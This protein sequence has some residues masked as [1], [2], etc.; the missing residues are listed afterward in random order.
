MNNIQDFEEWIKTIAVYLLNRTGSYQVHSAS[1]RFSEKI[2]NIYNYDK[3]ILKKQRTGGRFHYPF[4]N[5]SEYICV[6]GGNGK[7]ES[8]FVKNIIE[9][10]FPA[11]HIS[12]I[13]FESWR[14]CHYDD[15][16]LKYNSDEIPYEARYKHYGNSVEEKTSN[17]IDTIIKQ[18]IPTFWRDDIKLHSMYSQKVLKYAIDRLLLSSKLKYY[19]VFWNIFLLAIDDEI[20]DKQISDV[21][22]L[23]QLVGF[24]EA[25]MRDWCRAVEYVMEGNM[26]SKDCDFQCETDEGKTFF[27]HQDQS[28]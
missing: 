8:N 4:P 6:A 18:N 15:K 17:F 7:S 14:G 28:V 23:A 25:M 11:W 21:M 9:N 16:S 22:S 1:T 13:F 27:L 3:Y 10:I 26:F 12:D 19:S 2:N 5:S 24:N 20:Y